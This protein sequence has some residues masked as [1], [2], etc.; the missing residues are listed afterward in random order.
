VRLA[1][2]FLDGFGIDLHFHEGRSERVAEVVKP[3]T[4]L[5][6]LFENT[7]FD[8]RGT[9]IFLNEDRSRER[10]LAFETRARKNKLR[11]MDVGMYESLIERYG[12]E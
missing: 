4:Y 5:L 11:I 8:R 6:S 3:E 1:Q 12:D 10:L 2:E 9:K 7:C